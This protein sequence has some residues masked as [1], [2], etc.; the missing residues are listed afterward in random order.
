[1]TAESGD[2]L[3]RTTGRFERA[4]TAVYRALFVVL[5]APFRHAYAREMV[6]MFED[7]QRR[8]R[9][10]GSRLPSRAQLRLWRR[11]FA[12]LLATAVRARLGHRLQPGPSADAPRTPRSPRPGGSFMDFILFDLKSAMRSIRAN[13]ASAA[14][15]VLALALGI[16]AN[17]AIFSVVYGVLQ[18]LPY[19]DGERF[20]LVYEDRRGDRS[21]RLQLS[22]PEYLA[23]E[24]DASVFEELAAYQYAGTLLGGAPYP[25]S[26]PGARLTHDFM[27][28]L[29]ARPLHGR[30]FTEADGPDDPLVVVGYEL[31]Q[32]R[33]GGDPNLVGSTI[34]MNDREGPADRPSVLERVCSLRPRSRDS[35][36]GDRSLAQT[37]GDH[38]RRVIRAPKF[39]FA[40]VAAVNHLAKR[41]VLEP[42]GELFGAAFEN[43]VFHELSAY[44]AYRG[45]PFELSYWRLASGIEV[46]FVVDEARI[47]IEAKATAHAQADHLRG[48]RELYVDHP[49][50]Q[51]RVAVTLDPRP[52]RTNDGIDILPAGVFAQRLWADELVS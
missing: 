18:P 23:L 51:L 44:R 48:L 39:Y 50:L 25:E 30:E 20:A 4:A 24:H 40:D 29:G 22:P 1:M 3:L 9:A 33:W 14:V 19:A 31:W 21:G 28:L 26:V 36:R 12:A 45:Y 49:E 11:E 16:G 35:P 6:C 41:G 46:D 27:D 15:A 5:P 17:A 10:E 7:R 2:E 13:R 37:P 32:R 43:W 8:V 38:R 47:A 52:R 34:V 42:G